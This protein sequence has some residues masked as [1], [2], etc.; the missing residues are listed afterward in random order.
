[1]PRLPGIVTLCAGLV[2][3][4]A[5]NR[6][7]EGGDAP[8][9]PTAAP[10][11]KEAKAAAPDK[12]GPP[13][14]PAVPFVRDDY[15]GALAQ[16]KAEGKALFVDGWAPWCH[17]C[18]SMHHHVFT[19]P[20]LRPL[21]E[22]VVFASV[23]TDKPEN[24]AFGEAFRMAMWPT[25]FVIDPADERVVAF[26]PGAASATELV[27]FLG[28]ALTTL[29]K[30]H[31]DGVDEASL[32]GRL[33]KARGEQAKGAAREAAATY[34]SI[35]E[36]AAADWPHRDEALLGWIQSLKAGRRIKECVEVGTKYADQITGVARPVDFARYLASCA[37]EIPGLKNQREARAVAI[38]RLKALTE[39][40]DPA[41]SV[42]DRADALEG[43]A[44]AL[45]RQGAR[46]ASRA[47][48][49]ERLR[50]MEE[51]AAA[52]S[53][54][55]VAATYDYGRANAY[56]ALH[57]APEAIAMLQQRERELPES[58]EPPA[59]LADVYMKVQ[60]WPEALSAIDRALARAYGPRRLRYLS[61]KAEILGEMN[62]RAAQ[63]ETLRE[64]VLGRKEL[65]RGDAN[66][67]PYEEA[68]ERLQRAQLAAKAPPP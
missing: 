59:R 65:V 41:A 31:A 68:K 8:D 22:R 24:A 30:L 20:S 64:E 35:V 23:D 21:A 5:C 25:L 2:A 33:L 10:E 51:A 29:D 32:E 46:A 6:S 42:D 40:P 17:T 1:M 38:E 27:S 61:M 50:I 28:D 45:E 47:A 60:R 43:L 11:T 66:R 9:K 44:R 12:H 58:Y 67:G 54:P 16:A 63:I 39:R 7:E 15:A 18:L 36:E 52:A 26:W 3:L 13:P 48:D 4:P 62:D 57:R 14:E 55:E 34:G 37:D 56:V 49:E 53:S 19:D